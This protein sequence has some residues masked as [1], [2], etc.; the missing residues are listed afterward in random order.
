MFLAGQ[1][2]LYSISLRGKA[3]LE[4]SIILIFRIFY[5]NVMKDMQNLFAG[6]C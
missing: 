5:E 1:T 3:T 6:F 4:I 2:I